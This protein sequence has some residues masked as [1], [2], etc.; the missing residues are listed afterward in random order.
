MNSILI[1]GGAGFIGSNFIQCFVPSHPEY[2]VINIDKLTYAG[3]LE[4][5]IG[6]NVYPNYTFVKGD[7]CDA[8]FLNSLFVKFDIKDVIHFAA[9]SHVDKSIS[10]PESFITTNIVGTFTLLEAAKNHWLEDPFVLKKNSQNCRFH[11]ISTDEVFGTL[12]ESGFFNE[13]TPYAPNSPYSASKASSD[14]LVRSYHHTYGMDTII[15][16]CS[17]N[18]GPRQHKEKLIPTVICKALSQQK[19]P[20]YSRGQ[21]IRDWLFVTDHC[22]AIDCVFKK[23]LSGKTYLIG[24]DQ[25]KT[26]LE[27]AKIVCKT[28]DRMKSLQNGESYENFITFV[29]DRPGHDFRYAVDCSLLHSEIGWYPNEDFETGI[30]KTVDWYLKHPDILR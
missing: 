30:D 20:I 15:T 12:G 19:I 21:N 14:M 17:N 27:V 16:N 9:E 4:N 29:K 26:N 10:G 3:E 28:L 13:A 6:L 24:G 22:R 23:G 18:Y 8:P 7:I 2:H 11:H 1:T 25:E 5:L